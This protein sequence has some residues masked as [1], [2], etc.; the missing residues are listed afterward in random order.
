MNYTQQIRHRNK[1]YAS[2][3]ESGRNR[4]G[5]DVV[6]EIKVENDVDHRPNEH[7][8]REMRKP[9]LTFEDLGKQTCHKVSMINE[10]NARKERSDVGKTKIPG[11]DSYCAISESFVLAKES[12]DKSNV[13]SEEPSHLAKL[14]LCDT[15]KHILES[16]DCM[17]GDTKV[18]IHMISQD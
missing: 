11:D 18:H 17:L 3:P 9:G 7:E 12:I 16:I 1:S 15:K 2:N 14:N 10:N 8:S 6:T 5:R 4:I 13:A